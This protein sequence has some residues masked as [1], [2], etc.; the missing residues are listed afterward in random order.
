MRYKIYEYTEKG[1]D[2]FLFVG[3]A[4]INELLFNTIDHNTK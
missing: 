4:H 3:G 2:V 1:Y